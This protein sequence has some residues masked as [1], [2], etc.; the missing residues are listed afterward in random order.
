M[1]YANDIV[2]IVAG[3]ATANVF[4]KTRVLSNAG[5][6]NPISCAEA[7]AKAT[8]DLGIPLRVAAVTGDDIY[9]R[10]DEVLKSVSFENIDTGRPFSDIADRVL[11]ANVYLGIDPLC[12]GLQRGAD[13]VICG[14]STDTALALA[15]LVTEFGWADDDWNRRA[16]GIVAGHLIECTAQVTG[17]M[18]QAGWMDVPGMELLGYPIV[19]V[20]ADGTFVVTKPEGSGGVV[21]IST[22]TEQLLYEIQD[23]ARFETPDVTVDFTSIHL[24]RIGADRVRVSG[25]CGGPPPPTSK[26]SVTYSDG[27]STTLLWPYAEPN[28]IEKAEATLRRTTTTIDRLGLEIDEIRTDVF[29]AG[30]IM[31]PRASKLTSPPVEVLARLAAR[32]NSRSSLE[33]LSS[34]IAPAYS[35]PPGHAGFVGGAKGRVSQVVS[36]WPALMPREMVGTTVGVFG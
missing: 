23:P 8:S 20:E 32:S 13:V 24:E 15:P 36:H 11:S 5:G 1:G 35:G 12:E 34:E 17:G 28:A 30:A 4:G 25:V 16:A 10:L 3:L 14:R 2:P 22:V 18:H 9:A 26:V 33:R 21:D 7:I 31:G 6:V 19:E 27:W 29:G